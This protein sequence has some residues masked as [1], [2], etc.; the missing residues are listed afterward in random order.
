MPQ[1]LTYR[2]KTDF[3]G[4]KVNESLSAIF[5]VIFST[6]DVQVFARKNLNIE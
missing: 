1:F 2:F 6:F 5:K 4:V 3:V